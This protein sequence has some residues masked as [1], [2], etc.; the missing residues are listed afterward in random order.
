MSTEAY[1]YILAGNKPDA[2][3]RPIY[4]GSTTDLANRIEQHKAGT[5][6][7]HTARYNIRK[8]VWFEQH[9]SVTTALQREHRLKRWDRAWKDELIEAENPEWRDLSDELA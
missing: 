1:V 2:G 6:S 8:L 9:E 3:R 4:V 5:G 7:R